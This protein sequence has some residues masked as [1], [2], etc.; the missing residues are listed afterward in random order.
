MKL[1]AVVGLQDAFEAAVR[2][3]RVATPQAA[4]DWALEHAVRPAV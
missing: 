2:M 1:L 4:V 3:P